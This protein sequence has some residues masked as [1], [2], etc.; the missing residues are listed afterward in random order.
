MLVFIGSCVHLHVHIH[1]WVCIYVYGARG[2]VLSCMA[3]LYNPHTE[4]SV[5]L[6][7]CWFFHW[8]FLGA[9]FRTTMGEADLVPIPSMLATM[10]AL[11]FGDISW[12][13]VLLDLRELLTGDIKNW[14]LAYLTPPRPPCLPQSPHPGW[15]RSL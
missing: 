7:P 1:I 2:A 14:Y 15:L 3:G 4:L 5:N 6:A 8:F 9:F 10:S 11:V 12:Y 13:A